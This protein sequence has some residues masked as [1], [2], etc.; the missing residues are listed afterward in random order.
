MDLFLQEF[1]LLFEEGGLFVEFVAQG[2][3]CHFE[4]VFYHN[5]GVLQSVLQNLHLFLDQNQL[6]L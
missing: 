5:E 6:F 4:I 2:F 3:L 1:A